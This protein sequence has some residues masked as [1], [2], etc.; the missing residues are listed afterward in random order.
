MTAPNSP[1]PAEKAQPPARPSPG[2]GDSLGAVVDQD[3]LADGE[4]AVV[5]HQ[6][7]VK[8]G[9]CHPGSHRAGCKGTC[10]G[11]GHRDSPWDTHPPGQRPAPHH[12]PWPQRPPHLQ[13]SVQVLYQDLLFSSG[14]S[15]MGEK[16]KGALGGDLC[17]APSQT[18]LELRRNRQEKET[19]SR[20]MVR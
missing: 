18:H 5:P 9:V 2:P 11:H 19:M 6:E 7:E 10:W 3:A 20:M 13:G 8:D 12:P 16:D 17:P 1:S 4:G 14:H 15:R